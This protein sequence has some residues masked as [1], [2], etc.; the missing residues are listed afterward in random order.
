MNVVVKHPNRQFA[1]QLLGQPQMIKTS[2]NNDVNI[3]ITVSLFSNFRI[4]KRVMTRRNLEDRRC[5]EAKATNQRQGKPI[6][7][8]VKLIYSMVAST[9][10]AN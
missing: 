8:L 3:E 2:G 10:A 7:S 9:V 1:M 6:F 4:L 5:L